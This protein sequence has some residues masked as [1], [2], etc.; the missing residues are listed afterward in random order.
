MSRG[1][2][3]VITA[4]TAGILIAGTSAAIAVVNATQTT[5]TSNSIVLLPDANAGE[6]PTI[7]NPTGEGA[8]AS[9]DNAPASTSGNEPVVLPHDH[10][11]DDD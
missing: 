1:T 6:L 3:M 7:G 10:D 4:A 2:M 5:P 11:G 9:T 8:P